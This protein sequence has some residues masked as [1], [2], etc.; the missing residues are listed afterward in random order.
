MRWSWVLA[1][2]L[3][4]CSTAPLADLLDYARPARSPLAGEPIIGGVGPA[5]GAIP[6]PVPP[7]AEPVLPPAPG[8]P[9]SPPP[10]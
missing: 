2:L 8:S 6:P 4:G 3:V 7:G 9:I 10:L 1:I 5:P